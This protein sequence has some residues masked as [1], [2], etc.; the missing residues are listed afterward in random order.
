M[1]TLVWFRSDLRVDDNPA[2]SAAVERA[3]EGVGALFVV[4]LDQWRSHDWGEAKID[5][6]LRNVAELSRQLVKIG[7]PL[8]VRQVARFDDVLREVERLAE[9]LR[10]DA[11]FANR[12][13]E[14][15]ER[16]RD[17]AVERALGTA[18]RTVHWFH[19][20]A[21]IPPGRLSTG[22][23]APY[24]VYSPFRRAWEKRIDT[25]GLPRPTA[26]PDTV[27]VALEIDP[28]LESVRVDEL[29]VQ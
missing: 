24:S 19:D 16:R 1:R 26:A 28:G 9:R 4:C 10:C 27:D 25:E 18:G 8:I 3:D 21:V 13:Y 12:E 23:G 17:E 14:V 29:P 22:A 7:V 6:V 2:L 15:N 5:F 20:Q 11:V